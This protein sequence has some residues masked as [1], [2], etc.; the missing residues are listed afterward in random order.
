MPV[1]FLVMRGFDSTPSTISYG[2]VHELAEFQ[3]CAVVSLPIS[4]PARFDLALT[5]R[6]GRS[7][8]ERIGVS[9]ISVLAAPARWRR[10]RKEKERFS[11]P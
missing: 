1:V 10:G 8:S 2:L 5:C 3:A 7:G 11:F 9:S 6:E 4:G